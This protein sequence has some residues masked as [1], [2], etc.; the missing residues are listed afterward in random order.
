[1]IICSETSMEKWSPNFSSSGQVSP[2]WTR[3]RFQN[4]ELC[5]TLEWVDW[6]E[7]PVQ[8]QICDACGTINCASGGYIH[9]SRLLELVLWT[10]P[11]IDVADEW[12]RCRY[13]PI[14]PLESLG[15][16]GFPMQTWLDL[17]TS[18]P[19][20]PD[21]S[22]LPKA[23]C[24]AVV[25]AWA[26]GPGRPTNLD[27]LPQFL[28]TRLIACDTLD[29]DTAISSIDNWLDRLLSIRDRA[30]D[31][32]VMPVTQ[33]DGQIETM[34]FDGPSSKDWAAFVRVGEKYL[35]LLGAEYFVDL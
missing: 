12:A 1:M 25:D 8:V 10:T 13:S 14:F 5:N 30:I 3:L 22:K 4:T 35:P 34:Y 6:L 21:P 20:L 18:F 27:D 23:N 15:A 33:V 17:R 16:I 24:R 32:H 7:N 31:Q 26:L 19:D 29:N 2:V 11:Q 9:I 28:K